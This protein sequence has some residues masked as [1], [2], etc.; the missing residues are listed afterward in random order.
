MRNEITVITN[1]YLN[2]FRTKK[3]AWTKR[4]IEALG[5]KWPLTQGWKA[6]VI[7]NTIEP[8]NAAIFETENEPIKKDK[9]SLTIDRCLDYLSQNVD[10]ISNDQFLKLIDL[11]NKFRVIRKRKTT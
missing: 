1:T 7:G 3:G 6:D 9:N 11:Q 5:L 4:Q 10:G 8:K 2:E